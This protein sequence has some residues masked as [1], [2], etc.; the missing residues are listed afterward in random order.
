MNRFK[1]LRDIWEKSNGIV[2]NGLTLKAFHWHEDENGIIRYLEEYEGY[3]HER[4][5]WEIDTKR[6]LVRHSGCNPWNCW[7]EWEEDK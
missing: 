2:G 7:T 3:P 5:I 6:N 4:T 1:T